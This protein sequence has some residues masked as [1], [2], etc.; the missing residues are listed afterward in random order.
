MSIDVP[1]TDGPYE[2]PHLD[3]V[4]EETLRRLFSKVAAVRSDDR[5]L[6]DFTHRPIEVFRGPQSPTGRDDGQTVSEEKVYQRFSEDRIGNF[7]IVIEGEV[8]TGKSELCAYLAHR[9]E[10]DG[11]P[12]LHVDKDDD[13]MSLLTDRIPEF[14]Q[15]QFGE[16][17]PDADKY[18]QLQD[19]I[20]SEPETVANA[21][22]SNALLNLR[23]IGYDIDVRDR[24]REKLRKH[25]QTQLQRLTEGGEYATEVKFVSEAEYSQHRYLQVFGSN[26][27]ESAGKAVEVL[28]SKLWEF[29][30]EQYGTA[31]L[32]NVLERV[33]SRFED[34]RPVIVFEDFSIAAMEAKQLREYMERDKSEDNWDFIVAGTR[35]STQVL[36]QEELHTRTGEDRFEFYQTNKPDSNS[37]LFL[38]QDSAVD[39]VRPYL[40]YF[41][42]LD[43]SVQYDRNQ[44]T[45]EF[46]LKPAPE[47]SVCSRCGFCDESFRDLFPFNTTFVENIYAGLEESEQSPREFVMKTFEVLEDYYLGVAAAPSDSD[48]L[49]SLTDPVLLPDDVEDRSERLADLARWYGREQTVDD[50]KVISFD[51]RF[52]YAFD[53][54]LTSPE[55][56]LPDSVVEMETEV[57]I[58]KEK[59]SGGGGGSG[60]S[61]SGG[62]GGGGGKDFEE[63]VEEQQRKIGP[64]LEHPSDNEETGVYL[65]KGLAETI[66]HLTDGYALYGGS[67]LEYN[68]SS[69]QY[70]FVLTNTQAAPEEYQITIDPGEFRSSALRE[71]LRLGMEKD[72]TGQ[73]A[74]LERTLEKHGTQLTGY[75]I[76]WR[77]KTHN[78]QLNTTN[79]LFKQSQYGGTSEYDFTDFVLAAYTTVV[80]IDSPE[81]NLTAKSLNKRFKSGDKYEMDD[82][83]ER[84]CRETLDRNQFSTLSDMMDHAEYI[85]KL[86]SDVLGVTASTLDVPEMRHRLNDA[87]PYEVLDDLVKKYVQKISRRVRF[88]N[89]P[90]LGDIGNTAY[91]VRKVIDELV[92]TGQR[93]EAVSVVIEELD[94]IDMEYITEVTESLETYEVRPDVIEPLKRFTQ[95]SQD[96][97]DETVGLAKMVRDLEDYD[98]LARLQS[99]LLSV[100]V[101]QEE[102]YQRYLDVELEPGESESTLGQEFL[103]VS[104][105]YVK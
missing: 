14:Y 90:T 6:F 22:Y 81:K 8:G 68:L 64:W 1:R 102:A 79:V 19:D 99:I 57:Q 94:G 71:L 84:W 77:Q 59:V 47:G 3:E 15:K 85:E 97:I 24:H 86:M 36:Y 95:L 80:A 73:N 49:S 76:D 52:A 38:N 96:D 78:Q 105:H 56:S 58:V 30:R 89:R 54:D 10:D 45:G 5:E 17:L 103:E 25:V 34:T 41:K 88:N 13:L 7:V 21:A 4:S 62:S 28:N 2:C 48:M 32:N 98:Q 35:D 69:Q 93:E 16:V 61:G 91:N 9:L 40:G 26:G 75:A 43:G 60:G 82:A 53:V 20:E 67:R 70:P 63:R 55:A 74:N 46:E 65:R 42:S 31:S 44:D 27:P 12:I 18:E 51:K 23:E 11:R 37:V 104:T 92:D 72:E 33:G 50:K 66:E 29:V 100:I 83:V 39:F 87:Q 101:E